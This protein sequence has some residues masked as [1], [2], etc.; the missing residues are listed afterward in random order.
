MEPAYQNIGK[1]ARLA[2]FSVYANVAGSDINAGALLT[3]GAAGSESTH[4]NCL[5]LASGEADNVVGIVQKGIDVSAEI[6]LLSDG[7]I[8]NEGYKHEVLLADGMVFRVEY[9]Q[10]DTMAVA[11]VSGADITVTGIDTS[12]VGGAVLAISGSGIGELNFIKSLSTNTITCFQNH[13][14]DTDTVLIKLLPANHTAAV[15]KLNTTADKIGSDPGNSNTAHVE[16]IRTYVELSNG[17]VQDLNREKHDQATFLKADGATL[18]NAKF[19]SDVVF[20]NV[21]NLTSA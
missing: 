11:G 16:V 12:L 3:K 8:Y 9:D 7:S 1:T 13:N 19:Y 17:T 5:V 2:K 10:A 15:M 20:K 18:D 14:Y 6:G 4:G 21:A